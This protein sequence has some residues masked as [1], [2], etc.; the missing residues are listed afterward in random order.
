MAAIVEHLS[1]FLP[2]SMSR[3][4][5]TERKYTKVSLLV[6]IEAGEAL[7]SPPGADHRLRLSMR[8]AARNRAGLSWRTEEM[9]TFIPNV[10]HHDPAGL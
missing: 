2:G 10:T 9:L 6:T 8:G 5:G 7:A 3:A 1:R 4:T